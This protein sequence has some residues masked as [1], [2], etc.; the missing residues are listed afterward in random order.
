M[1]KRKIKIWVFSDSRLNLNFAFSRTQ[2]FGCLAVVFILPVALAVCGFILLQGA[3]QAGWFRTEISV[4]KKIDALSE[5]LVRVKRY[6]EELK[7]RASMLNAV[8]KE[9]SGLESNNGDNPALSGYTKP[10]LKGKEFTK[11]DSKLGIGEGDNPSSPVIQIR[12]NVSRK[13]QGNSALEGHSPGFLSLLD[14][15]LS[16]L[17][18]MP[19]GMPVEGFLSSGF[20]PRISPFT[21]GPKFHPGVDISVDKSSE[22]MAT[23]DGVV[24]ISG[25]KSGYGQTVVLDHGNGVETLYGH[26]SSITVKT[27]A[28]ICRGERIGLVGATGHATGPHLHYEVRSNGNAINPSKF[29]QVVS[30][31][32]F[33]A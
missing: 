1:E 19:I 11:N 2:F 26:L 24:V 28:R 29:I 20:G 14:K 18:S 22:V 32:K 23:A 3:P 9:A 16:I 13:F 15:Q 4:E 8:L 6:E 25:Y 7:V 30:F 17:K 10:N 27:G 21:G 31:L 5:E 12:N 33:L